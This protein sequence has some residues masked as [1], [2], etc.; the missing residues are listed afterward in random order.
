MKTV[1][2]TDLYRQDRA[3]KEIILERMSRIVE[4]AEFI[5]SKE[6][7]RFEH[8]FADY[9][10]VRH[11]VALNSG[12]D[13][14]MFAL[15]AAGVEPG[16]EVITT[17]QSFIATAMAIEC[18]GA[19]PVL[20]D[21]RLDTYNID[22]DKIEEKVTENTQAVLPVHYAGRLADMDSNTRVGRELGVPV[23]EDAAQ[24]AGAERNGK[25]AGAF[26]EAGCFSFHPV[27]NLGAWGD[28]GCV[29]TDDDKIAEKVFLLGNYGRTERDTWS[30]V[31]RNSRMDTLQAA[32][33]NVKLDHLDAVNKRRREIAEYYNRE[34]TPLVE[35]IPD[36]DSNNE[37]QVFHLYI[38]LLRNTVNRDL[39]KFLLERGIDTRIHY[40]IPMHLQPALA[41]LGYREGDFPTAERLG[42]E[43]L[44]LP[45]FAEMTDREVETVVDGIKAYYSRGAGNRGK[46]GSG[47]TSREKVSSGKAS[48][49]KASHGKASHGK[50]R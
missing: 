24:A 25:K 43:T 49:G 1:P 21:C 17:S 20:L 48:H 14:L 39:Q 9:C 4:S 19:K 29:T 12:T 33:L 44:T 36:L 8:N 11:V 45:V 22:P 30:V 47:K 6:T 2:F 46:A 16:G 23:I 7:E 40:P 18:I 3:V 13:A 37:Q 27:K 10:G 26:S 28:A 38:I 50:A 5:Q 31:G 34:L 42:R 15:Q 35:S 41:H 32:V